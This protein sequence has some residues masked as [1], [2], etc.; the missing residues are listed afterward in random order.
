MSCVD[1]PAEGPAAAAAINTVQL[2]CG[3]F[4][5]GLAGVVVNL[6]DTGGAASARWAFAVF[7][8]LAA[9]AVVAST[10]S[11]RRSRQSA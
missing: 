5:A 8:L 7:A 4:G 3:S 1:D 6:T 11:A 10:R 2:I 9:V